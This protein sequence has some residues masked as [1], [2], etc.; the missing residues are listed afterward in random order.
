MIFL[1]AI[2]E[3][4]TG[5]GIFPYL[6]EDEKTLEAMALVEMLV[7]RMLMVGSRVGTFTLNASGSS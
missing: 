5:R 4:P 6:N 3:T 2:F 7:K 1:E